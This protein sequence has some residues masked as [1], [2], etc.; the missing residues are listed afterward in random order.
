MRT[1]H[2]HGM[3]GGYGLI[4]VNGTTQPGYEISGT[5]EIRVPCSAGGTNTTQTITTN[6]ETS[7]VTATGGGY[8]SPTSL[9][10]TINLAVRTL[11]PSIGND[12]LDKMDNFTKTTI[13]GVAKTISGPCGDLEGIK[14]LIT[15]VV[16]T[17]CNNEPSS[18]SY[19]PFSFTVALNQFEF[20]QEVIASLVQ[21][22]SVQLGLNSSYQQNL[23]ALS[24]TKKICPG[25][26][27][28]KPNSFHPNDA[29]VA[30]I[31]GL[32]ISFNRPNGT[33]MFVSFNHLVIKLD[34][35]TDCST[36]SDVLITEALNSA[37][38]VAQ[39]R[40]SSNQNI[41]P[42]Q[43]HL[44]DNIEFLLLFKEEISR[45]ADAR[46]CRGTSMTDGSYVYPGSEGFDVDI[47]PSNYANLQGVDYHCGAQF[48]EFNNINLSKCN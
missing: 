9:S 7:T 26:F 42:A 46:G 10:P 11:L 40:I 17:K 38:V 18:S 27:V 14:N 37:I 35:T 31:K 44:P 30:G 47:T 13:T 45:F 3:V 8:T 21:S 32:Q 19:D 48:V 15:Q 41:N 20:G 43:S 1:N 22:L 33:T 2:N 6:T 4:S 29:N 12:C 23:P 39:Q 34:K 25:F 28:I 5:F 24:I 16:V 36:A